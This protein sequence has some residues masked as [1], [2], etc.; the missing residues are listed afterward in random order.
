MT[1][2]YVNHTSEGEWVSVG[3]Y[4]SVDAAQDFVRRAFYPDFTGYWIGP[5]TGERMTEARYKKAFRFDFPRAGA[6]R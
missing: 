3:P 5:A 2:L 4:R 6:D 1:A